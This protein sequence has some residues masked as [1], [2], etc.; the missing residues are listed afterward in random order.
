MIVVKN[1]DGVG[2]FI[3]WLHQMLDHPDP[4]RHAN[5][6]QPVTSLK[7]N[8]LNRP[9]HSIVLVGEALDEVYQGGNNAASMSLYRCYLILLALEQKS[10]L[11]GTSDIVLPR[12]NGFDLNIIR[13]GRSKI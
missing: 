8:F 3:P 10:G 6:L 2:W 11:I 7:S 4:S 9:A 13:W 1:D 5:F 12:Q